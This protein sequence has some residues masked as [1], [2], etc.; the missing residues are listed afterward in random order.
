[1]HTST[2]SAVIV[3][4]LHKKYRANHAL[5]GVQLEVR[6]GEVRG[7]LGPNGAGKTTLVKILTTLLG[8]DSGR[9]VVN[10]WSVSEQPEK[11]RSTIGMAGQYSTVDG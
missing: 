3:D 4:D 7:L 6:S 9:V 5:R 1:M 2:T 11:V 10:G 8:P